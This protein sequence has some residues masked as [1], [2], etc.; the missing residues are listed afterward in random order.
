MLAFCI[1]FGA[2]YVCWIEQSVN[3]VFVTVLFYSQGGS[4][5]IVVKAGDSLTLSTDKKYAD[6]G[7]NGTLYVDYVNITKVL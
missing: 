4:A 1:T 3:R 6:C 7:D 5:E 2:S